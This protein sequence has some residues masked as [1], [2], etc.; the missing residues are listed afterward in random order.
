MEKQFKGFEIRNNAFLPVFS[1]K[2]MLFGK[3]SCFLTVIFSMNMTHS[4]IIGKSIINSTNSFVFIE[5]WGLFNGFQVLEQTALLCVRTVFISNRIRPE[6]KG[7]DGAISYCNPLA[8]ILNSMTFA[9]PL[10]HSLQPAPLLYSEPERKLIHLDCV[11]I[12]KQRKKRVQI[13]SQ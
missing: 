8:Y 10:D 6:V 11:D 12:L 7:A 1:T 4:K 3:K 2:I 5:V 13:C 9:N